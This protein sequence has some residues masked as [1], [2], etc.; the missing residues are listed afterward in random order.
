[1]TKQ[2]FLHCLWSVCLCLQTLAQLPSNQFD[3]YGGYL[4]IKGKTTGVFH[5]QK[6]H[7]RHFFI[8]PEGHG[9]IALGVTHTG[10][11][12]D[13]KAQSYDLFKQAYKN[14]RSQAEETI[15][16]QLRKWGYNSLGYHTISSSSDKMPYVASCMVTTNSTWRKGRNFE[17]EDIFSTSWKK[18]AKKIVEKMV[19]KSK[20]KTTLLGYYWTD[21]PAWDLKHS[22]KVLG[23]NWVD[24]IR[25]LPP[26]AEGKK[27]YLDFLDARGGKA[28]DRAFLILI[29]KEYYKTIGEYTRQLDPNSLILG[30]RYN[31]G[32]LNFDVIKEALPYIDV[33]S[34]QPGGCHFE[35][36]KFDQLYAL[37]KKPIMI[38]DHQCS[39]PTEEHK[40]TIWK[41]LASVQEVN[42][43][44]DNYLA[45]AFSKPYIIGYN[46]C[47]YI[48]RVQGNKLK[49]GL[50]NVK[51]QAREELTEGVSETNNKIHT[52]FLNY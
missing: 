3:N 43:S 19:L 20:N 4:N 10:S 7:D 25:S 6:L 36:D 32:A 16:Q 37:A 30:D 14:N 1:M 33:I 15:V 8:T 39:F 26:S 27:R 40:K 23:L 47:Q 46:R 42:R 49:Q 13:A 17:Y 12:L 29:A 21:M 45:D 48:D 22:K 5:L 51:G 44:H 50:V 31:G 28:D 9:F 2:I 34:V 11:I 52:L 38:C 18:K 24:Y 35:S 41:Q